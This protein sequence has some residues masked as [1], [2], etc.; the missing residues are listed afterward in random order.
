MKDYEIQS[1]FTYN[2]LVAIG[3][4]YVMTSH[5]WKILLRMI[6]SPMQY[7]VF[8]TEYLD[9]ATAQMMYNLTMLMGGPLI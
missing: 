5:D 6:L 4:S 7:T 3:D 8:I 2:L 1:A 9:Q